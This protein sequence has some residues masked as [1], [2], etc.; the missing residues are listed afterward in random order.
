MANSEIAWIR[1]VLLQNTLLPRE[2]GEIILD[3]LRV[4]RARKDLWCIPFDAT[5]TFV[6]GVTHHVFYTDKC[7]WDHIYHEGE[8]DVI[9]TKDGFNF[10]FTS[11][12][13][14]YEIINGIRENSLLRNGE[15]QS[16]SN[17]YT[18]LNDI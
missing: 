14:Y 9:S 8:V 15:L 18:V 5:F 4:A 2:L 12:G 6:L 16:T 7:S 3:Y 1:P 10:K 17:E 11:N 13:T